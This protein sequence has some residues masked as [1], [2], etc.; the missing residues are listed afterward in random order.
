MFSHLTR[1]QMSSMISGGITALILISLILMVALKSFRHGLMSLIPNIT[2][3]A[4]GFGIWGITVGE[5]N[6]GIAIVF[7]MTLGIIVDDTVH[8]LSKYLRAQREQNKSAQDAIRYAFKTVGTALIVTTIVLVFGFGILSQSGFAMNSGMAKIT[9]LTIVL[10]LIIDFLM[11]PALLIAF[12]R[13]KNIQP[14][15]KSSI[16]IQT[17][18]I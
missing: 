14:E 7:G 2:P 12:S 6:T 18:K 10:A 16:F 11:L 8:F 17:P 1:R 4:V 5:I 3:I 9:A 15:I 13:H